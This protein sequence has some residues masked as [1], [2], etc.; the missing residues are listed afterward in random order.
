MESIIREVANRIRETRLIC[1][2]GEEEMAA[3][4]GVTLAHYRELEAGEAD[5]SFTFTCIT[6]RPSAPL[7]PP[8]IQLRA[9]LLPLVTGLLNEPPPPPPPVNALP[10]APMA[11]G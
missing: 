10:A 3:C 8:S 5:F 4:T 11:A 2:I 6:T 1:E 9:G 7:P